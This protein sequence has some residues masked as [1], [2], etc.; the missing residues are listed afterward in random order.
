MRQVVAVLGL[1]LGG[2][3]D[4]QE[5]RITEL[6]AKLVDLGVEL[7][8]A[9]QELTEAREA[10]TRRDSPPVD[11]SGPA[12]AEVAGNLEVPSIQIASATAGVTE[13]NNVWWRYAYRFD[14]VN[15]TDKPRLGQAAKVKYLNQAGLIVDTTDIGDLALAPREQ[16]TLDGDELVDF[17]GAA[18]VTQVEIQVQTSTGAASVTLGATGTLPVPAAARGDPPRPAHARAPRSRAGRPRSGS[19]SSAHP[20]CRSSTAKP[21]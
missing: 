7:E 14:L 5:A 3:C 2:C 19:T 9:R 12:G 15:V 10:L 13:Q 16:R 6:E 1:L 11:R 4:T 18:T 20:G 17:P 8:V 21:P